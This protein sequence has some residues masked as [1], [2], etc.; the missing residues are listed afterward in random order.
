[1]KLSIKGFVGVKKLSAYG[2]G[3]SSETYGRKGKIPLD[4]MWAKLNCLG[5]LSNKKGRNPILV[6]F[7]FDIQ[8]VTCNREVDVIR[9][10]SAFNGVGIGG[11]EGIIL[12]LTVPDS[13]R[14]VYSSS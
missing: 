6:T 4:R 13:S 7:H 2:F 5:A 1:M 14:P 12:L 3:S 9:M 8:P 10:L 11:G